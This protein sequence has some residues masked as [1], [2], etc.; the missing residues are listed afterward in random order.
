MKVKVRNDCKMFKI[1]VYELV[2]ENYFIHKGNK[3]FILFC[4]LHE[5]ACVRNVL[6]KKIKYFEQI[7]LVLS[8]MFSP[9]VG[10]NS[11]N[12]IRYLHR[13]RKK[14]FSNAKIARNISCTE[15][16]SN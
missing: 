1:T 13:A 12:Y 10:T 11:V 2:L 7:R 5:I 3:Y 9:E 8:L 6:F 15:N 14:I 4:A 16:L